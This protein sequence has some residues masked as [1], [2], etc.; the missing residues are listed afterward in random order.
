[1]TMQILFFKDVEN[2]FKHLDRIMKDIYND[3]KLKKFLK[4]LTKK[5]EGTCPK[6]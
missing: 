1:M 2:N 6:D 3:F 5:N 4:S